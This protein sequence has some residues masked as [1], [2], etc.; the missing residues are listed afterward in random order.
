[1]RKALKTA[2][3][4]ALV[5]GGVVAGEPQAKAGINEV[6]A[7]FVFDHFNYKEY[8]KG[9]V[10]DKETGWLKGIRLHEEDT[11]LRVINERLDMYFLWGDTDY[12]GVVINTETGETT[13]YSSTTSNRLFYG[14]ASL[15]H[16]F[17]VESEKGWKFEIWPAVDVGFRYWRRELDTYTEHY[18]WWFWGPSL[19][20]G[21]QK[22]KFHLDTEVWYSKAMNPR[23]KADFGDASGT[24]D[25][26]DTYN[27]GIS[28]RG[29]YDISKRLF[30][31]AQY[32]YSY[33][34]IDQSDP[35]EIGGVTFIE[36]ESK[37]K[38]NFIGIGIGWRF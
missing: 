16:K 13:P 38:E 27:W 36:P 32:T 28:L 5:V 10:I 34:K 35:E 6:G 15:G 3:L 17:Q 8:Y 19:E 31:Y 25:L 12:D 30:A 14:R 7:S 33:T 20:V 21:V 11:A 29:E 1:M 2:L 18:Y 37:T 4:T 23:L 22:G 24:V 26:G 9:D